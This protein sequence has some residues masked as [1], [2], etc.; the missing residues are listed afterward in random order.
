VKTL[1]VHLHM[2]P[3]PTAIGP[4]DLGELKVSAAANQ[5][6]VRFIQQNDGA[7]VLDTT[8]GLE[9]TA[10]AISPSSMD[11]ED[12]KKAVAD[13]KVAGHTDWRLPTI[14]ELLTLVDYERR[15]PAIN[16][17]F[18]TCKSSYYW[19][20][21]P[22]ASSSDFAWDVLFHGGYSDWS[23]VYGRAFVRAVRAPSQ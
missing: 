12:A 17:D 23:Y 19:S 1:H 6:A 13:A 15:D 11:W 8:T 5:P 3:L 20:S 14:Q 10:D 22:V 2:P 18:F 21:T 4:T 7:T 16:T 9:W